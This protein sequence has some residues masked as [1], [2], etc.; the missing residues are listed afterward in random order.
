MVANDSPTMHAHRNSAGS[1]SDYSPSQRPAAR[2]LTA[3]ARRC[4]QSAQPALAGQVQDPLAEVHS[5]KRREVSR[6][7]R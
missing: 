1:T 5:L 2:G 4:E 6:Q 3:Y 7:I